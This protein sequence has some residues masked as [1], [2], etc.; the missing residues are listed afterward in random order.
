MVWPSPGDARD[1]HV[2]FSAVPDSPKP[3][4]KAI[5]HPTPAL[6]KLQRSVIWMM[7]AGAGTSVMGRIKIEPTDLCLSVIS[8]DKR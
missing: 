1:I 4:E 5:P 8:G 3:R 7:Q 2:R 6:W